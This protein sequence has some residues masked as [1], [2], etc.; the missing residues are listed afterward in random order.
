MTTKSK[1]A[2]FYAL[3]RLMGI[4]MEDKRDF[5]MDYTDGLTDSLTVLWEKYPAFY[6]DMIRHMHGVVDQIKANAP[7]SEMDK[8]RKRLIA[9]IGGYL[10][11][12]ALPDGIDY[13]KGMACKASGYKSFNA[14]PR[15]RLRNLYNAFTKMQKDFEAVDTIN[16]E[17]LQRAALMN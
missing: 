17:R 1:H 11:T 14:I 3:L 13:I 7:D 15:E 16:K 12:A 2:T 6:H 5:L 9:A 4:S 8:L 10:K